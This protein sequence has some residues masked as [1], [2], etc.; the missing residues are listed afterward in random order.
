MRIVSEAHA[1][2]RDANRYFGLLQIESE[3][4]TDDNAGADDFGLVCGLRNS[5]DRS[6]PAG[7]IVGASAFV[8]DNLS[9]CGEIRI[10]RRH[11]SH[12]EQDVPALI[13]KAIGRL[14]DLRRSQQERFTA[15][16]NFEMT[17]SHAHDLIVRSLDAH[18]IPVTRLPDVLQEWRHPRH[19]EFR[20][21]TAFSLFNAFTENLKY[22]LDA[23]PVRTTALHGLLD[24]VCGLQFSKA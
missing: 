18:V 3:S 7:L 9:F 20:D 23:L 11:T 16:K 10:A 2:S 22:R 1:L 12:I 5:H 19:P 15:Y 21:R 14:G 17:D 24:S 13:E 6:Y 4:D 8:C